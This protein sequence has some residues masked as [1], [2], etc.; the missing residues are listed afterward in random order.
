MYITHIQLLSLWSCGSPGMWSVPGETS[1]S[2]MSASPSMMRWSGRQCEWLAGYPLLCCPPM[3]SNSHEVSK[4]ACKSTPPDVNVWLTT[5]WSSWSDIYL[6]GCGV[7]VVDLTFT[8]GGCGHTC[9]LIHWSLL[10]SFVFSRVL[11]FHSWSRLRN[12]FKIKIC[13]IG[14]NFIYVCL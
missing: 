8:S 3:R 13:S 9:T 4:C 6:R 11:N 10:C 14:E 12:L 1:V 7:E 5:G 2:W